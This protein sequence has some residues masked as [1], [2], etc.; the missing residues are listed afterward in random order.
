VLRASPA[1]A[2]DLDQF[3][4]ARDYFADGEF[5]EAE[6]RLR[7]LVDG[8]HQVSGSALVEPSRKYLAA[9]LFSLDRRPQARLVIEEMLRV[10]PDANLSPTLF[11]TPLIQFFYDIRQEMLPALNALRDQRRRDEQATQSRRDAERSAQM[12]LLQQLATREVVR[13]R[14]SPATILLP[15]GGA[16]FAAGSIALGVTFAA[17]QSVSLAAAITSYNLCPLLVHDVAALGRGNGTDCP[18]EAHPAR[19]EFPT[20]YALTVVNVVSWSVFGAAVAGGLLHGVITYRPERLEVRTRRPP[21]GFELIR[22]AILPSAT[23]TTLSIG[24]RF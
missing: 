5:G 23:T 14:L 13:N 18:D 3:L 7:T 2:D 20:F 12:E 17:V 1:C 6:R 8:E 21:P 4:I 11:A 22:L 10:N 19:P 16:Q 24:F 9:A 15:F